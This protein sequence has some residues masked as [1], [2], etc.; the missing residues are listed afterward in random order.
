[1]DF[2]NASIPAE[3]VTSFDVNKA[4]QRS[5]TKAAARHG[6]GLY[7]YAGEDLPEDASKEADPV[8]AKK[9]MPDCPE[10]VWWKLVKMDVEGKRSKS[11]LS[12]FKYL[13][14]K[15]HTDET[16]LAKFASDV[17][18]SKEARANQDFLDLDES[19]QNPKNKDKK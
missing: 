9:V 2:K 1:M 6:L 11:G 7:I 8:P 12:G 15:Y 18:T 5:L 4:I 17:K 13:L 14:N 3:R 10:D 16:I 19:K